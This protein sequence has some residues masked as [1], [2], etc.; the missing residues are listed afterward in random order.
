MLTKIRPAVFA[1]FIIFLSF[2]PS[3]LHADELT[4]YEWLNI[5]LNGGELPSDNKDTVLS[6]LKGDNELTK[7]RA[8]LVDKL[9][10]YTT[11]E[12]GDVA[13]Q[14]VWTMVENGL[15]KLIADVDMNQT[16]YAAVISEAGKR[17]ITLAD[18][19]AG[20]KANGDD[21]KNCLEPGTQWKENQS[22]PGL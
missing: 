3:S 22:A 19:L 14:A 2:A 7:P 17:Q 8:D 20:L 5:A 11:G 9:K 21:V 4:A 6:L 10:A 18:V 1:A 13:G 12:D 16:H 15:K